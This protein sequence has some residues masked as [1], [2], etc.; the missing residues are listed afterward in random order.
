M[1]L[2]DYAIIWERRR[3]RDSVVWLVSDRAG[4]I[5][6][7]AGWGHLACGWQTSFPMSFPTVVLYWSSRT[8]PS[9][10][11][12]QRKE[13][14]PAGPGM[15]ATQRNATW[16]AGPAGYCMPPCPPL[17]MRTLTACS[18]SGEARSLS[19]PPSEHISL[20]VRCSL[21]L[22]S[23]FDIFRVLERTKLTDG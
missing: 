7:A 1:L 4:I 10:V 14:S 16:A 8:G 13:G 21:S 19:C 17:S 23:C 2:H 20:P 12:L 15:Q 11:W 22:P 18:G 3:G 6:R 5:A 9:W